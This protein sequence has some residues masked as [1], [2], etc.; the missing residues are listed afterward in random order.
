MPG[1]SLESEKRPASITCGST[2]Q[3]CAFAFIFPPQLGE[4]PMSITAG[5]KDMPSSW[6]VMHSTKE[7]F[8]PDKATSNPSVKLTRLYLAMQERILEAKLPAP[9]YIQFSSPLSGDLQ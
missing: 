1:L 5:V 4:Y 2:P 8:P 6:S 7:S 3:V 9:G